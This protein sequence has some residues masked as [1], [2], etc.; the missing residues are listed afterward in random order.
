M[1]TLIKFHAKTAD[2]LDVRNNY[3][4]ESRDLALPSVNHQDILKVNHLRRIVMWRTG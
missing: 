1:S 2:C 3:F 4:A